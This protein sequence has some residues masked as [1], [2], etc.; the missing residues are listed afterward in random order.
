MSKNNNKDKIKFTV[1]I[2]SNYFV[3]IR[4]YNSE[5]DD[6]NIKNYYYERI[7]PSNFNKWKQEKIEVKK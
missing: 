2:K 6:D 7:E 5:I 3:Y 4:I 1:L